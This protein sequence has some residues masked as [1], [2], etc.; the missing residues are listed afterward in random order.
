M[1]GMPFGRTVGATR[2]RRGM[3]MRRDGSSKI[4]RGGHGATKNDALEWV[5]EE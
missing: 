2:C 4:E 5:G 3:R 1:E